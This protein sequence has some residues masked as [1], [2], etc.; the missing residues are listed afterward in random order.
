MNVLVVMRLARDYPC[1]SS[2]SGGR[3]FKAP[4]YLLV[5]LACSHVLAKVA[6]RSVRQTVSSG[7]ELRSLSHVDTMVRGRP[8]RFRGDELPVGRMAAAQAALAAR[9]WVGICSESAAA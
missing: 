9:L 8:D 1:R 6:S 7:G 3:C 2:P 5:F 4:L